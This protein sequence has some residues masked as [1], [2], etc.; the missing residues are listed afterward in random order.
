MRSAKSSLAVNRAGTSTT[1]T[2]PGV[3]ARTAA[4]RVSKPLPSSMASGRATTIGVRTGAAMKDRT[5][6]Q[7]PAWDLKGRIA[8]MEERNSAFYKR[9]EQLEAEKAALSEDVEVKQEVVA[10]SSAE[11]NTLKGDNDALLKKAEALKKELESV[12][13]KSEDEAKKFKRQID[14]LEFEKSSLERKLKTLE[15]ELNSKQEEVAGLKTSVTSSSAGMEAELKATKALLSA[16]QGKV[17]ELSKLSSEQAAKIETHEENER[18]FETERR[19][20]HNT[21]QELKG[22]I[23]VFCRIRPLLGKELEKQNEIKHIDVV[24]AK[25][26]ALVKSLDSPN[27]SSF[28]SKSKSGNKY[29]FEFDRVFAAESTQAQVFDE[30]SQLVQSAID[31][32]NVCVFAY[33]QT[34]SGKTF[35]MEGGEEE[36]EEQEGMIPRTIDQIFQETQRLQENGWKYKMEATFLEIYNEEVRDLLA[37]EKNLKYEI[38]MSGKDGKDVYVTNVKTEVVASPRQIENLLKRA[39]K[40]R[41]VAATNCNE[42]SS[43]SHSVFQLKISGNNEITT[44]ACVGTLNLVDLA[45]SERLKDSGSEGARL[46]E[47]KNIN[48]SLSNLGNVIMALANKDS[49]V[50]YRNSKL[51]HLLQPSLGGNS[52]TLMFV[53][54]SPKEE[55]FNETLNSLRFAAKVNQCQIGTATKRVVKQ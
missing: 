54:V 27:E 46:V 55:C 28:M 1:T 16:S 53:N 2:R 7:L 13:E 40:N 10:Q 52:K 15:D 33:G 20:L 49:H 25:N 47:T 17:A 29:D 12:N 50:P 31:G 8:Q 39:R 41:A 32:Y 34:G 22:N 4:S 23:R 24:D 44:E 51:T 26:L 42:R 35:T 9:V 48:K 37:T 19:R 14:D 5:N 11:L 30:I 36:T 21:I 6:K 3:G 43:R 18:A 38:K 45:G